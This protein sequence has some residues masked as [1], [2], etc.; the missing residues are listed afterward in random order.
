MNNN[1]GTSAGASTGSA[2]SLNPVSGNI[3]VGPGA[4]AN[5]VLP[6]LQGQGQGQQQQFQAPLRGSRA[7]SD[8]AGEGQAQRPVGQSSVSGTA[9]GEGQAQ[10][11]ADAQGHG[12]VPTSTNP[13]ASGGLQQQQ[14]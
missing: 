3:G 2:A 6:P 5:T 4:V 11:S 14:Q 7:M 10:P 8:G 12:H 9:G 1:L 13:Y